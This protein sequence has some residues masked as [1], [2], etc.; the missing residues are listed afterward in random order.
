MY[1]LHSSQVCDC[2][3]LRAM[4]S[5]VCD[6]PGQVRQKQVAI[7]A[8]EEEREQCMDLER[9]LQTEM[10]RGRRAR[11]EDSGGGGGD[12][13]GS[14]KMLNDRRP[15]RQRGYASDDE[16]EVWYIGSLFPL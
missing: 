15:C 14:S 16:R 10:R 5:V 12:S 8:L 6:S 4:P 2:F 9:W 3:F 1:C 7:R 13:D 11:T